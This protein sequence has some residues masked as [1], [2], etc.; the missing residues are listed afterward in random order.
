MLLRTCEYNFARKATYAHEVQL[1]CVKQLIIEVL[2]G[3][4]WYFVLEDLSQ[5]F[6]VPYFCEDLDFLLD[7]IGPI[8]AMVFLFY[9]MILCSDS[10]LRVQC[11][12]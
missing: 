10:M 11:K 12:R 6:D 3:S 5:R 4:S 1:L 9:A 2:I 8:E 7:I